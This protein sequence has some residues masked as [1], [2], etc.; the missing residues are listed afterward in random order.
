MPE[1]KMS[2][3]ESTNTLYVMNP[4]SIDKLEANNV[5]TPKKKGKLDKVHNNG[6]HG[7]LY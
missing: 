3:T 4:L 6:M 1:E 2:T 7:C 5:K